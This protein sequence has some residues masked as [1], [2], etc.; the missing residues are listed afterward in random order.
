MGGLP[1]DF[2][3]QEGFCC[4]SGRRPVLVHHVDRQCCEAGRV[5][6]ELPGDVSPG[7]VAKG[8]TQDVEPSVVAQGIGPD[9]RFDG[10]QDELDDG[11]TVDGGQVGA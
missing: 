9:P 3:V 6:F 8:G 2:L 7:Q 4:A 11:E 10:A 1:C 5:P